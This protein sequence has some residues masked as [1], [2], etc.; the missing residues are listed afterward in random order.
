MYGK[1]IELF[2]VNGTAD[3]IITAELSNW[4]GKAIKIPRIEVAECTREDIQNP[5]VYFLFCKDE[6]NDLESVYIGEAENVKE[7]LVQHLR[8]AAADKEKYYWNTAIIFTG[9]DLN[10]ALI[11]YLEHNLVELAKK[12]NRYEILT[13]N[14]YKN[15]VLK[16]SQ[17]AAMNEFID[18]IRVLISALGYKVL[19]PMQ[20]VNST[21]NREK[22]GKDIK[23]EKVLFYKT[24][25]L[26][27]SC[28]MTAEGFVLLAGSKIND[29][30][31]RSLPKGIIKRRKNYIEAGYVDKN[32]RT[33]RDILFSSSTAALEF[34]TGYS[35]S[36]NA[37]WKD[38]NGS[39]LKEI[40]SKKG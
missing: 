7:R 22:T 9:R 10:K 15:T 34:V 35:I 39:T 30:I 28:A 12:N 31:E 29:K 40:E 33:S 38:I 18:N 19:E 1:S 20:K 32:M 27:A 23:D 21:D 6:E 5:G 26:E 14:T 3:S 17:Q 11:R 36:G 24:S 13:K 16:E 25:S 4:N 37:G 8:D 2:L